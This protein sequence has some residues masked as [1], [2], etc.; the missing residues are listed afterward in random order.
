MGYTLYSYRIYQ[1]GTVID[2]DFICDVAELSDDII[3]ANSKI[4]ITTKLNKKISIFYIQK[5]TI[6]QCKCI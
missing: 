2:Q 4:F 1:D 5:I 3:I 6:N